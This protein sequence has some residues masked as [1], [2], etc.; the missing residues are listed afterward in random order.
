[1][2]TNTSILPHTKD[3]K[4]VVTHGAKIIIIGPWLFCVG[5]RRHNFQMQT[6]LTPD[7]PTSIIYSVS[8]A[9]ITNFVSCYLHGSS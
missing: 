4:Q 2:L 8:E 1:M 3:P 9:V 6:L 5:Q 7:A